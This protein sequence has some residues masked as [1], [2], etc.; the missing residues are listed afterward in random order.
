MATAHG[1]TSVEIADERTES[2]VA[3]TSE[4]GSSRTRALRRGASAGGAGGC[5]SLPRAERALRRSRA[6]G[7]HRAARRDRD[8]RFNAR[9][10]LRDVLAIPDPV[11]DSR[12]ADARVSA[13][14]LAE[15]GRRATA[16][17]RPRRSGAGSRRRPRAVVRR[18]RRSVGTAACRR[19]RSARR[20]GRMDAARGAARP[21]ARRR[22]GSRSGARRRAA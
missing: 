19:R 16:G 10:R 22:G 11:R 2:D 3:R 12:R 13:H 5:R 4:A 6:G 15:A 17:D 1:R 21:A 8:V 9:R 7:M 20:T 18:D 14:S